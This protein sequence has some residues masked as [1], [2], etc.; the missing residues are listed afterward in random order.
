MKIECKNI[1]EQIPC[2]I[3]GTLSEQESKNVQS[4]IEACPVCR[5][6]KEAMQRDDRLLIDYAD[7]MRLSIARMEREVRSAIESTQPVRGRQQLS[8]VILHFMESKFTRFAA[9]AV[10]IIALSFV[11]GLAWGSR[12]NSE[13][14]RA[15]LEA[16]LKH[17]L[18]S[19]IADSAASIR[20]GLRDE[21]QKDLNNY[22]VQTMAATNQLLSQLV[23]AIITSRSQDMEGI[24]ATLGQ[25]EV[26]RLRENNELRK[27]L[28]TFA[29]YTDERLSQTQ[30]KMAELWDYTRLGDNQENSDN[31]F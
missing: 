18:Q 9:A 29:S 31:G 26:N 30:E 6:Y 25:I 4:H 15:S 1:Q 11:A 17:D 10:L 24:A 19:A 2:F 22:A 27:D 16:S 20:E 21:Y 3:A 8:D 14:I 7:S 23:T 5:D 12:H 28:V 13:R